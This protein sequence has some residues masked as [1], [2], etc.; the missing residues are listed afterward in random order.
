MAMRKLFT[1]FI[2]ISL[3]GLLISLVAPLAL[4][5]NS[6]SDQVD[7]F[8]VTLDRETLFY[9][10]SPLGSFSPEERARIVSG[11]LQ[12]IAE[13]NLISPTAIQVIEEDGQAAIV[14]DQ[15]IIT[16]L[17]EADAQSEFSTPR[18]L[19]DSYLQKIQTAITEYRQE[20]TFS[21]RLLAILYT[22]IAT[23]SVLLIMALINFIFPRIKQFVNSWCTGHLPSIRLQNLEL[24][25][26]SQLSQ[27]IVSIL[28]L[29]RF[30]IT[31]TL[32]YF[33]IPLILSFFPV[34]RQFGRELLQYSLGAL[35][36]VLDAVVTYIPN[37]FIISLIIITTYYILRFTK[38]IFAELE[39]GTLSLP[40]FYADWAKPTYN[41]TQ[42][43]I[44]AMA[45]VIAF[46][47]LPGFDS[48]AFRGLSVFLGVLFSLGSTSVISNIVGGVILIYTRAFQ[49][50]DL[51][52]I[53]DIL[54]NVEE[55]TLFVTRIR[56]PKNLIVTLP[57][58][59]VLSG[60]IINYSASAR[61]MG[62]PLIIHTTITLGYDAPW[63]KVHEVLIEAAKAT[64][65][66]I[67]EPAPYVLQTSLD[68]FYVSYQL[69]AYTHQSQ[70]LDRIYSSLH[71][72]IQDKC[73]EAGIEIMSPGYTALRDGNHTTI[74]ENYLNQGYQAPPFKVSR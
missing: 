7:G 46:P 74:P 71:Q 41:L 70:P 26:S 67:L 12:T 32:F 13:D 17:T 60:Q 45:L 6:S 42:F 9:I 28:N 35:R 5:Q 39:S 20:R 30:L 31:L 2:L 27:L 10:K 44:M 48:P 29:T 34:T 55:K 64:A 22:A 3:L 73:N 52:K 36:L 40:G 11:R 23:L 1:K 61:E 49:L 50:G 14:A 4:S 66:V 24:V 8:P 19:A 58:T 47:Y 25:K 56:T 65:D 72:N 69:N 33:Y 43:F 57:N 68:D 51:V 63:R 16:Y 38:L 53:G 21:Y 54:G 62:V 18:E 59:Q 15:K 37:I